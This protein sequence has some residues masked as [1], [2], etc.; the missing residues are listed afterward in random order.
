MIRIFT[1]L[2]CEAQPLIRRYNLKRNNDIARFQVF[3]NED[4]SLAVTGTGS[5]SAAV[6]V[7]HLFT[8][9]PSESNDFLVNIG[10]CGAGDD[11]VRCGDIFLCNKITEEATGRTFYPDV[12][13]KHPFAE[14]DI[15]TCSTVVDKSGIH[16]GRDRKAG[17][18]DMEAAGIYQAAAYYLQPHRTAFLKVASDHGMDDRLKPEDISRLI[19]KNMDVISEWLEAIKQMEQV[20]EPVFSREEESCAGD[21]A[22]KLQCSVTMERMLRQRLLYY[23][24]VNGSFTEV[25]EEFCSCHQLPCKT[26][27][28]GKMY[29]EKFAARL[30]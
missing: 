27:A 20:Y 30:I 9:Y 26:R 23:K 22:R 15:I 10:I 17:L 4:I 16:A 12:I 7:S 14:S 6:A 24:L 11:S 2:H 21:M 5:I 1:A 19:D 3:Q 29:F 25:V 8:L 13:F 28:E 18:F